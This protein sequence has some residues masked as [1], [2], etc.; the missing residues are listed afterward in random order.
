MADGTA[1]PLVRTGGVDLDEKFR[2]KFEDDL[3]HSL[4]CGS[5][6]FLLHKLPF[7]QGIT[8]ARDIGEIV[9]QAILEDRPRFQLSA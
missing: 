5:I 7:V 3:T 2:P 9:S 6:A 4:Y 8:S 1:A